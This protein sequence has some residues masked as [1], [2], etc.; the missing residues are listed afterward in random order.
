MRKQVGSM[1]GL[2]AILAVVFHTLF[3]LGPEAAVSRVNMQEE[4]SSETATTSS[5]R[6]AVGLEGPWPATRAFFKSDPKVA[7]I[8]FDTVR[9]LL[10]PRRPVGYQCGRKMGRRAGTA[11]KGQTSDLGDCRDGRGPRA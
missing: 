2:L 8:T 11:E 7:P 4:I 3:P 10:S 6:E 1:A 9:P 5:S